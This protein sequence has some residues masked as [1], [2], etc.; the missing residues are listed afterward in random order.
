M[1]AVNQVLRQYVRAEMATYNTDQ[2]PTPTGIV[3][4][5]TKTERHTDAVVAEALWRVIMNIINEN[6][7]WLVKPTSHVVKSDYWEAVRSRALTI[8]GARSYV[9]EALAV[10]GV[11]TAVEILGALVAEYTAR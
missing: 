7:D 9:P 2:P 3:R 8:T 4:P 11:D 10:I 6:N 1:Y 5:K